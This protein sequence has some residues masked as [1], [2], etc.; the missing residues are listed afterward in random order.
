MNPS[1]AM[2]SRRGGFTIDHA[3][4]NR[5]GMAFLFRRPAPINFGQILRILG[6]GPRPEIARPTPRLAKTMP[7][8]AYFYR[9]ISCLEKQAIG[10]HAAWSDFHGCKQ[11]FP[12][13]RRSVRE[14]FLLFDADVCCS[15][16]QTQR[17][18]MLC[19]PVLNALARVASVIGAKTAHWVST[20]ARV[21]E[22]TGSST[23]ANPCPLLSLPS[24]RRG[25][26]HNEAIN[27]RLPVVG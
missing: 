16:R 12:Q 6:N 13:A 20:F 17:G 25:G 1:Q 7:L 5:S 23:M 24:C 3:R 18:W 19:L 11:E 21:V 4:R 10:S 26:R 8:K 2:N 27:I 9:L 15:R 14:G 22:D